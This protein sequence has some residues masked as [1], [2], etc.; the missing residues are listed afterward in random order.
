MGFIKIIEYR[1]VG[2]QRCFDLRSKSLK[3]IVLFRLYNI[4]LAAKK[5]NVKRMVYA[6]SIHAVS[7][8]PKG[9]QAKTSEPPN[10]GDLYGIDFN[11]VIVRN[12]LIF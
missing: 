7:G 11:I 1:R 9:V 6:S 4:F 5:A 12:A 2:H 10:P 3:E 8:Y